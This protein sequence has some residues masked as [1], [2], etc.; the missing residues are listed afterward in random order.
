MAVRERDVAEVRSALGQDPALPDG[1]PIG[2]PSPYSCPD[3]GGVLNEVAD[4][5]PVRFRC[6]VGHAYNGDSLLRHQSHTFEDALWTALRAVQER[7]EVSH[8]L[9]GEAAQ[10]GREWSQSHYRRR[11]EE[12]RRSAQVLRQVLTRHQEDAA[13]LAGRPHEE[14]GGPRTGD[15][16]SAAYAGANGRRPDAG[17]V[18]ATGA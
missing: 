11:A 2:T 3:C 12:A 15:E 8:R 18:T 13:V 16:R 7:E 5:A 10:T 14:G 4:D 6:R 9:A 1:R 17:S